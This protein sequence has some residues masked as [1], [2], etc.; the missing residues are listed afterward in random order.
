M[1]AAAVTSLADVTDANKKGDPW[2]ALAIGAYV[3][4]N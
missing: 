2:A 1:N 4:S 3:R